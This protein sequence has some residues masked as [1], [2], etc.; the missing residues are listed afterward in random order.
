MKKFLLYVAIMLLYA[1]SVAQANA[2]QFL[3][4]PIDG[5]K[6][7][8]IQKLKVKGFLYD[9]KLDILEGEFN[10]QKVHIS[11]VTDNGKVYRIMLIDANETSESQIKIRFN[12]LCYQF[13]K[14]GKY[15]PMKENQSIDESEDISYE[16]LVHNKEYQAGFYQLGQDIASY[17]DKSTEELERLLNKVVWFTIVES[18]GKYVIAMYYDNYN[19]ASNGEDL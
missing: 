9:A 13:E 5:T 10:G 12:T 1:A 15:L 11:I 7:E 4:I 17:Y 8:M 19:N 2:T 18:Y 16:M 3:G 6:T 14:N